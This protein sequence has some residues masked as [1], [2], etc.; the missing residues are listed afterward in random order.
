MI[1]VLYKAMTYRPEQIRD[2]SST[3]YEEFAVHVQTK[4]GGLS[5]VWRQPGREKNEQQLQEQCVGK[6]LSIKKGSLERRGG[7]RGSVSGRERLG[8]QR[9][10][11]EREERQTQGPEQKSQE[12]PQDSHGCS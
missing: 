6:P 3:I 11:L 9:S 12:E 5:S 10:D 1:L 7:S 4:P 2:S 8:G